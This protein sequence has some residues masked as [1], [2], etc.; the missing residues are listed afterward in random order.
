MEFYDEL[1]HLIHLVRINKKDFDLVKRLNEINDKYN[2]LTT[3]HKILKITFRYVLFS[4]PIVHRMGALTCVKDII[5]MLEKYKIIILRDNIPV[6]T[7]PETWKAFETKK[8]KRICDEDDDDN[9]DNIVVESVLLEP[10]K[11]RKRI[12]DDTPVVVDN[13]VVID[14]PAIV[15]DNPVV[16]DAPAVIDTPSIVVDNPVVMKEKYA[17][18]EL[19]EDSFFGILVNLPSEEGDARIKAIKDCL[20]AKGNPYKFT[21]RDKDAEIPLP[22]KNIIEVPMDV[23]EAPKQIA[24]DVVEIPQPVPMDKPNVSVVEAPKQVL[25]GRIKNKF[26]LDNNNYVAHIEIYREQNEDDEIFSIIRKNLNKELK[27]EL[28]K[29]I[30]FQVYSFNNEKGIDLDAQQTKQFKTQFVLE[31]GI[32]R[33]EDDD[34]EIFNLIKNLNKERKE[35]VIKYVNYMVH[36]LTKEKLK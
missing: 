19:A 2:E 23:L 27:S 36:G 11:K 4:N 18:F 1:V 10:A 16:I 8:R 7:N 34:N 15:V 21:I 30:N 25:I 29:F 33:K 26:V 17:I 24:M 14:T 22:N 5:N 13:P 9:D 12:N 6:L 35:L 20:E 28:L 31:I 3:N 32:T